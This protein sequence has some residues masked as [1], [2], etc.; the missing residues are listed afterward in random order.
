MHKGAGIAFAEMVGGR[1]ADVESAVQVH[2]D[3]G[4]PFLE[5]HLVEHAIAQDAGV[6]DHAVKL[7]EIADRVGHHRLR[8]FITR[9]AAEVGDR[10]ATHGF[11]FAHHFF[12]RCAFDVGA[13]GAG[14]EIVHHHFG[15]SG[16]HCQR[17]VAANA[18][19]TASHQ[20]HFTVEHTHDA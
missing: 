10:L 1:A 19:S 14:T 6:I 4:V 16:R 5:A 3:H 18:T 9:D 2:V 11:D 15:A 7:A 17:K 20:Y 13:V 8:V 12:G